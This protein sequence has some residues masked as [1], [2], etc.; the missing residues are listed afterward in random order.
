MDAAD[1]AAAMP[2]A[3]QRAALRQMVRWQAL[4]RG[5]VAGLVEARGWPRQAAAALPVEWVVAP[6]AE[7]RVEGVLVAAR[8]LAAGR[9]QTTAKPPSG[10]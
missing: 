10:R 5:A 3:Q 1:A 9:R 6:V 7:A 4:V 2:V 8:E